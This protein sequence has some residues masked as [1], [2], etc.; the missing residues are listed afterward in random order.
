MLD[1]ESKLGDPQGSL[2]T[3]EDKHGDLSKQS[4]RTHGDEASSKSKPQRVKL[5]VEASA[6]VGH[7]VDEIC[8]KLESLLEQRDNSAEIKLKELFAATQ[9]STAKENPLLSLR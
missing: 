5:N 7:S 1:A 9:S 8:S 3:E 6:M 2:L 4:S